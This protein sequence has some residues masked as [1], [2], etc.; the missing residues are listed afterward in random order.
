MA[1]NAT[2]KGAA[3]HRVASRWVVTRL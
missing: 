1:P 2:V 3:R